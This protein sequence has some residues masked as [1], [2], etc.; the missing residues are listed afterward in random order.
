MGGEVMNKEDKLLVIEL[1]SLNAVPTVYYKG[2]KLK[3]KMRV[4]FTW[5]TMGEQVVLFDSPYINIEHVVTDDKGKPHIKRIGYN[6]RIDDDNKVTALTLA[7]ASLS[8]AVTALTPTNEDV[9]DE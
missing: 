2:E 9:E 6:E 3:S 1:D 4:D 5:I 7:V 8:K